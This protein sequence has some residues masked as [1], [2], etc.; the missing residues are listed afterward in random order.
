MSRRTPGRCAPGAG[1]V[2]PTVN[3]RDD[4][5]VATAGRAERHIG[6]DMSAVAGTAAVRRTGISSW[7]SCSSAKCNP[8][9]SR[10][11]R[12]RRHGEVQHQH[13]HLRGSG[14][15]GQAPG[16]GTHST[17]ACERP[18]GVAAQP[19]RDAG[20]SLLGGRLKP[21]CG[22]RST[23]CRRRSERHRPL[24]GCLPSTSRL[25]IGRLAH[26]TATELR[27]PISSTSRAA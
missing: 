17:I 6:N 4:A 16:S 2:V 10:K 8:T 14:D 22:A 25:F 1:H 24:P 3:E 7:A 19:H 26:H 23:A 13:Q 15:V 21:Q 20:P 9:R 12:H 5:R 18:P 11:Q 27:G